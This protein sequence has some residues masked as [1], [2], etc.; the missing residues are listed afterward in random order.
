MS[1]P[2]SRLHIGL[3]G[4]PGST[5][6]RAGPQAGGGPGP[7]WG[8]TAEGQ[9]REPSLWERPRTWGRSLREADHSPELVSYN[10]DPSPSPR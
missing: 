8:A 9:L 1:L 6:P 5:S 10:Q 2:S 7:C 4:C 3:A